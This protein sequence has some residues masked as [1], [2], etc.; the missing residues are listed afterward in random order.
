MDFFSLPTSRRASGPYWR[1]SNR[2]YRTSAPKAA[3]RFAFGRTLAFD[4]SVER[5]LFR[6]WRTAVCRR[7][8]LVHRHRSD[9]YSSLCVDP[10]SRFLPLHPASDV[11]DPSMALDDEPWRI[12][13]SSVVII[14]AAL[15]PLAALLLDESRQTVFWIVGFVSLLIVS[16][17]LQPYLVP[18]GLSETFVTWFFVL[19]VGAVIAIAFALLYYFVVQRNFF[20]ERS[21]MLLLNILPKEISE[22]LK[23][24]QQ[25][26]AAQYQETSILFADVVDFTPMAATMTPMRLLDLLDEVFQC[27]DDLVEKYDL[28]KIKTI[29]DCYMV[30]AGVPRSCPDHARLI[31]N[32]ALDMR[33]AATQRKFGDQKLAFRIGINSGPVVA[34][35]IGRKKFI[36]DLWGD[37]VNIASRME[38]QGQSQS[39]Q[40]TSNTFRLIKDEFACEAKG[41][42][43]VKGGDQLEVWHVLARKATLGAP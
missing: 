18:V 9:Q 5:S 16:A 13:D 7:P 12:K 31:V 25:T 1:R 15:C 17:I 21:E 41:T 23:A 38:S 10:K 4:V 26:I 32:L 40:I 29:G 24:K 34:G 22:A 20:Q 28:E 27:F 36:Y 19:N 42:I 2:Q 43:K 8:G 35:V 33:E 6:R 14:W 30:A 37:A 39:I 3:R 11:S